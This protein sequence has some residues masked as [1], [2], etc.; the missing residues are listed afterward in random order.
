MK[1]DIEK[2]TVIDL[3][4]GCGGF[5]QGFIQAGFDIIAAN[6]FW[7]PAIDTYKLNHPNV[8]FIEGDITEPS[9][10]EQLYDSVKDKRVNVVIGGPPCQGYSIAGDRDP[11]DA[12]GQLYNDFI[13]IVEKIKPDI[14]VMENVKGLTFMKHVADDINKDELKLFRDNCQKLQRYKELKRYSAQRELNTNEREE[15][16]QVKNNLKEINLSIESKL[17]PLQDKII[18][19]FKDINYRVEL[20]VLNSADYGVAQTRERVIFI[21]TKH[22]NL[23]IKFPPKSHSN[24]SDQLSLEN[25][26]VE[27]PGQKLKK[28]IS[29]KEALEKYETW[30]EDHSMSHLFTKHKPQFIERIKNTPIGK[31]VFKTY[32]DSWWRLDPNKPARTV[33]E[34]H[35]GVFVHY[36]YDRVCTPRELAALQSFDDDFLYEGTKS[37]VLKQI[38]NAVPPLLAKAIADEINLSL[39]IIYRNNRKVE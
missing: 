7:E 36:E 32:T 34:N 4:S 2:Y 35:G 21:G 11:E 8:K 20:K 14:F 33:K 6:E 37:A 29:V 28:W 15:F 17:I 25:F 38:G 10:K 16:K 27:N 5:G 30:K 23:K 22:K 24:Q 13:E 3:F 9:T 12:R 19:R 1:E 39:N 26:L 31:N 18:K